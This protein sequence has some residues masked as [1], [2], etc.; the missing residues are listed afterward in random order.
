MPDKKVRAVMKSSVQLVMIVAWAVGILPMQGCSEADETNYFEGRWHEV[1]TPGTK[2]D[3]VVDDTTLTVG[4][5]ETLAS[6]QLCTEIRVCFVYFWRKDFEYI[7]QFNPLDDF[8]VEQEKNLILL[9]TINRNTGHQSLTEFN[10]DHV[11]R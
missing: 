4:D 3:I 10:V 9:F 11:G 5:L 2:R 1:I 7:Q 6:K 8:T